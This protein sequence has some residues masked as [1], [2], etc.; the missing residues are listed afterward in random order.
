MASNKHKGAKRFRAIR[1]ITS[2]FIIDITPSYHSQYYNYFSLPFSLPMPL[3]LHSSF[4]R[5]VPIICC[6][7]EVQEKQ[8]SL[9]IL[10]RRAEDGAAEATFMNYFA[11]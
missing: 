1:E 9:K 10:T 4:A 6:K 2:I 7:E 3:R 11:P 5:F 8:F